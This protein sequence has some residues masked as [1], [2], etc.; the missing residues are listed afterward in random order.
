ME[1]LVTVSMLGRWLF[2]LLLVIGAVV[3]HRRNRGSDTLIIAIGAVTYVLGTLPMWVGQVFFAYAWNPAK[4][5]AQ[6]ALGY[7]GLLFSSLPR[8]GALIAVCGFVAYALRPPHN[9]RRDA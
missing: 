5:F 7:S 2:N 8:I 9:E 3:L 1:T 4:G 6:S